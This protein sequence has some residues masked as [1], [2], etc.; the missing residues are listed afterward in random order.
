MS[1]FCSPLLAN[2]IGLHYSNYLAPAGF[3]TRVWRVTGLFVPRTIR[4]TDDSYLS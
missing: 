4:T 2:R 1:G 3:H